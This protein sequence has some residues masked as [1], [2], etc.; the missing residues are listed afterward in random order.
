[1]DR[2]EKHASQRHAVRAVPLSV[3]GWV[4]RANSGR[5]GLEVPPRVCETR[6]T[7]AIGGWCA[8][9]GALQDEKALFGSARLEGT[10]V[11]STSGL[12]RNSTRWEQARGERP[13]P[14]GF[15]ATDSVSAY[16]SRVLPRISLKDLGRVQNMTRVPS[17]L[18]NFLQDMRRRR[19]E[20]RQH[21]ESGGLSREAARK[22]VYRRVRAGE[23]LEKVVHDL[24]R[25]RD[26]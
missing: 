12:L 5:P 9:G 16:E 10:R 23:T 17:N 25:A 7:N 3:S 11:I 6:P 22:R 19:K 4:D 24:R 26:A 20:A 21:F 18:S 8:V 14:G 15:V 2:S 1:M 13:R